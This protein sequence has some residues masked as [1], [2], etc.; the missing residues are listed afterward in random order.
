MSALDIEAKACELVFDTETYTLWK[1]IFP[2]PTSEELL[3]ITQ[4]L[5]KDNYREFWNKTQ[6]WE[7]KK[8][9]ALNK[10]YEEYLAS[11]SCKMASRYSN[12]YSNNS[13]QYSKFKQEIDSEFESMRPKQE[14]YSVE[15]LKKLHFTWTRSEFFAKLFCLETFCGM[16]DHDI[17]QILTLLGGTPEIHKNGKLGVDSI[18][19]L[20]NGPRIHIN[21]KTKSYIRSILKKASERNITTFDGLL[22]FRTDRMKQPESTLLRENDVKRYV[23]SL[24]EKNQG[25]I[26][27]S[28]LKFH[29]STEKDEEKLKKFLGEIA[30]KFMEGMYTAK[31][32]LTLLSGKGSPFSS[33]KNSDGFK[34]YYL[35]GEKLYKAMSQDNISDIEKSTLVSVIVKKTH[36]FSQKTVKKIQ[37]DGKTLKVKKDSNIGT[38][39]EKITFIQSKFPQLTFEN[40]LGKVVKSRETCLNTELIPEAMIANLQT[41]VFE[42]HTSCPENL[43]ILINQERIAIFAN[44]PAIYLFKQIVGSDFNIMETSPIILFLLWLNAL[45]SMTPNEAEVTINETLYQKTLVSLQTEFIDSF[46]GAEEDSQEWRLILIFGVCIRNTKA[47]E[48]LESYPV[49][50]AEIF[51]TSC[52]IYH[53]VALAQNLSFMT[54]LEMNKLFWVDGGSPDNFNAFW[55]LATT[56]YK[57]IQYLLKY[58][59]NKDSTGITYPLEYGAFCKFSVEQLSHI[60]GGIYGTNLRVVINSVKWM[61]EDFT[62]YLC[63]KPET[64]MKMYFPW[65]QLIFGPL[66]VETTE[67]LRSTI[68]RLSPS[69]FTYQSTSNEVFYQ[70]MLAKFGFTVG[71]VQKAFSSSA[72]KQQNFDVFVK[73]GIAEIASSKKN[74]GPFYGILR[75]I[76][77]GY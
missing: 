11:P 31:H 9:D 48:K 59:P 54:K 35:D 3:K 50:L 29:I 58:F 34:T 53:L 45:A 36:E 4:K 74:A 13:Q 55:P 52:R 46:M 69:M 30:T 72:A 1:E 28:S 26:D 7:R 43:S 76:L 57:L 61:P 2:E 63:C 56:A 19:E 62:I 51:K 14:Q 21:P 75:K 25:E 38:F 67:K 42:Q 40:I 15:Y 8:S 22:K 65:N 73:T 37:T 47:L 16:K 70:Q 32:L 39:E 17:F 41:A 23:D 66:S 71:V 64:P 10:K 68:I 27:I 49:I 5:N 44:T 77:F 60:F 20:P 12:Q 18:V 24:I 33:S 6:V